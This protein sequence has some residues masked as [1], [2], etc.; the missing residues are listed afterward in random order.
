MPRRRR[1][2]PG[3]LFDRPA[4]LLSI[5]AVLLAIGWIWFVGNIHLH[6][7]MV[8]AVVVTLCT[9]FCGLIFS[10]E[11]LPFD[12]HVRDLLQIWRVPREIA[13]DTIIVLGVLFADLFLGKSAPS[14]YRVSGF[15]AGKRDPYIV[16]RSTLAVMYSTMSPNMIVIG[17]DAAQ[18]HM[19][20]HQIKRDD[21]AASAR[22]LGAGH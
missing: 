20:F 6:E 1:E 22:A 11:R 3:G 16:G 5:T 7:M 13:K 14:L 9:A 17:I 8:G 21:V 4:Q 15:R 10:S 18:G 2:H 19:L 12:L